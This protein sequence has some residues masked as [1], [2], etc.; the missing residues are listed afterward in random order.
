MLEGGS[1]KSYHTPII[2]SSFFVIR[3]ASKW[4]RGVNVRLNVKFHNAEGPFIG[5]MIL[6]FIALCL[7]GVYVAVT[8]TPNAITT[9]QRMRRLIEVNSRKAAE[10]CLKS[11]GCDPSSSRPTTGKPEL[12]P[13]KRK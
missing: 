6:I 1:K 5:A 8:R 9:Q 11:P 12:I 2:A 4:R 10:D 3:I 7:T 13:A